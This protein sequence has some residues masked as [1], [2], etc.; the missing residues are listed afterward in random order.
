MQRIRR[1]SIDSSIEKKIAIALI[2]STDF[3]NLIHKN[4]NVDLFKIDYTKKIARWCLEYWKE[5]NKAPGNHIADIYDIEKEDMSVPEQVNVETFLSDLSDEYENDQLNTDYIIKQAKGYFKARGL[6]NLY[7]RGSKLLALGKVDQ[8]KALMDE[9]RE[10]TVSNS[11]VIKILS[12]EEIGKFSIQDD[13]NYLF[14]MNGKLGEFVGDLER[15]MIISF[16][17]P[18]K[19]GKSFVLEECAIEGAENELNV[20][21]VSAEMNEVILKR[22]IY[23]R[24]TGKPWMRSGG[25]LS[26]LKIPAMDC[27]NNQDDSCEKT[28]RTNNRMLLKEDSTKPEFDKRNPYRVCTYC[29]G[30]KSSDYIPAY[31][32]EYIGDVKSYTTKDVLKKAEVFEKYYGD[33]LRVVCFPAFSANL[34]DVLEAM[35][36]LEFTENFVVDMLIIDMLDILGAEDNNLSERGNIDSTWKRFKSIAASRNLL[37][38]NAEQ[39]NK[40]SNDR[41][42]VKTTDVSE[43]KR[44][45]A[46]VDKKFAINQTVFERK[47]GVIRI[48]KLLDRHADNPPDKQC[49]V[50]QALKLGLPM[51]DSEIV[52]PP[53][54]EDVRKQKKEEKKIV[55]FQK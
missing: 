6:E 36:E 27:L 10:I 24:I 3:L 25:S 51:I 44:K 26:N 4:L 34:D 40:A 31:W 16:A 1:R 49:M 38:I 12:K 15:S 48:G 22:R 53:R 9:W 55:K 29:R 37:G 47:E 52:Y 17:A 28:Q 35:D 45:N 23:S 7:E 43:D 46:H 21:L 5:F 14:T 19:R 39:S 30:D 13:S 11:N 41:I 50:L 2:T 8:A 18:E 32:F 20:L 33:H 54:A 42:S